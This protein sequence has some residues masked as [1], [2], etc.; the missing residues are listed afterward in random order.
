MSELKVVFSQIIYDVWCALEHYNLTRDEIAERLGLG[1]NQ[2]SAI[3]GRLKELKAVEPKAREQIGTHGAWLFRWG[4]TDV[5]LKYSPVKSD[6]FE[7]VHNAIEENPGFTVQDV[8]E[9][10]G[11]PLSATTQAIAKLLKSG[12]LY[13]ERVDTRSGFWYK[14]YSQEESL[15]TKQKE[16]E[17][18]ESQKFAD[19]LIHGAITRRL[20]QQANG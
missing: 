15:S 7:L 20:A 11:R 9:K 14:Y 17:W 19:S 18:I 16:K 5:K 1:K 13:R 3:I 4:R 12:K 10:I 8:S 2:V 6:I